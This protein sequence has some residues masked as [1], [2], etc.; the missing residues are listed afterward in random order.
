MS[1][2][3]PEEK[4][5]GDAESQQGLDWS[6]EVSGSL[7]LITLLLLVVF[8]WNALWRAFGAVMRRDTGRKLGIQLGSDGRGCLEIW[9]KHCLEAKEVNMKLGRKTLCRVLTYC[10]HILVI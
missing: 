9:V 7:I 8:L 2:Q 1:F 3:N 10:F 4:F 6:R 5:R